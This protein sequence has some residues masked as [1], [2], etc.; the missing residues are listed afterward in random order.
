MD[1]AIGKA[2]TGR[3]EAIGMTQRRLGEAIGV[4]FPAGAEIRD[5][6]EPNRRFEVGTRGRGIEV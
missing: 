1:V 6:Q 2:I 4:T 5:G 3:R